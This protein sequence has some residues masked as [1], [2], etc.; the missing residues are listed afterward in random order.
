M[1]KVYIIGAGP[2]DSELI[3][4]KGYKI[5]KKADVIIYDRLISEKLLKYARKDAKKIYAGKKPYSKDADEKQ[6]KI[7]KLLVEETKK[8][9]IVV[10]L[11]GGDP[12]IFGRVFEEIEALNENS[13]EFEIIPGVSSAIA[14]P[15]LEGIPLTER[16]HSSSVAIVTGALAKNKGE[17]DYSA[18]NADTLVI[19]MGLK[20]LEKIVNDLLKKRSK[21][22]PIAIIEK[23]TS[24]EGKIIVSTLGKILEEIKEYKPSPPSIIVVG[25]VVKLREKVKWRKRKK[26]S[27]N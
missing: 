14:V 25:E 4:L 6:K 22:T 18:F 26:K 27:K 17:V 15:G 2:G 13:I 11:K 8:N 12:F 20:N 24:K 19:L 9:N 16:K 21:N 10:R 3:T 7:N 1:G 5:L 23:G